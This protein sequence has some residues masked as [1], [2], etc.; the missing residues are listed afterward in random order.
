M[1]RNR[2]FQTSQHGKV[3]VAVLHLFLDSTAHSNVGQLET[4]QNGEMSQKCDLGEKIETIMYD[5]IY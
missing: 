2:I 5:L 3:L 4:N 1:K